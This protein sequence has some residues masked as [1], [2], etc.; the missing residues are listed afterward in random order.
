MKENE[1]VYSG[2]VSLTL[3]EAVARELFTD[4]RVQEILLVGSLSWEDPEASDIDLV[5]GVERELGDDLMQSF[6]SRITTF[7]ADRMDRDGCYTAKYQ[8]L[9]N[10]LNK[11]KRPLS[12][13]VCHYQ[14]VL[15]C[16]PLPL[17]WRSRKSECIRWLRERGPEDEETILDTFEREGRPYD[18]EQGHFLPRTAPTDRRAKRP[19]DIKVIKPGTLAF[20]Y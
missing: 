11:A 5:V 15:D 16:Y 2:P 3:A 17:D 13:I 18:R 4:S 20:D 10:T 9:V 7:G 19:S 8:R 12:S 14:R 6:S 1:M